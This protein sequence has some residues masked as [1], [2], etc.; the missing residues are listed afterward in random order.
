VALLASAMAASTRVAG[1]RPAALLSSSAARGPRRAGTRCEA[2]PGEAIASRRGVGLLAAQLAAGAALLEAPRAQAIGFKKELKKR[3]VPLSEYDTLPAFDWKG[4]PHA[5]LKYYDERL[6]KGREVAEGTALTC[7]F[8]VYYR[9]VLVES[10]REGRLIGR[11]ATLEEPVSFS[12]GFIPPEFTIKS[13]K[14]YVTGVGIKLEEDLTTGEKYVLQV[15]FGSPAQEAGVPLNARLVAVDG[16]PVSGLSTE[17]CGELLRGD[18]SEEGGE[19]SEVAASFSVQG[20]EPTEYKLT[21][22]SYGVPKKKPPPPPQGAN[23]LYNGDAG[24]K[25]PAALFLALAGMR[26]GGQRLVQVPADVGYGVQG[27]GEIAPGAPIT[28][29]IEVLK[30]QDL[31]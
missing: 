16:E 12:Y 20:G 13:A 19:G 1:A 25:P 21:R 17:R 5:G 4:A 9:N 8:E 23:G 18:G 30:V 22:K 31:K 26:E 24:A 7:H 10:S 3:R 11:N 15:Y 27:R 29:K 6:G 2:G 14:D 28:L